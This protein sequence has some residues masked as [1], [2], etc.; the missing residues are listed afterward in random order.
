L[1]SYPS[2]LGD[3]V[4]V[5][6]NGD[7]CDVYNNI[8]LDP[9]FCDPTSD[10][11]QL[12]ETS[13]CLGAGEGMVDIGAHGIGCTAVDV[14][15]EFSDVLPLQFDLSQNYPNPFNP[16]TLIE[17]SLPRRSHV[18]IEIFNV[19]GQKVGI[20]VDRQES[21]G[22]YSI[23]WDG[24]TSSGQPAATGVYLYRFQAGDHVKTKRMLLLK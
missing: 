10:D 8:A 14:E 7:F 12:V 19:L 11:Y 21:A 24:K 6:A 22:N 1:G 3:L 15:E 16:A 17:Y 18:L 2:G 20:L 4:G 9:L 23:T 5:N 13:P